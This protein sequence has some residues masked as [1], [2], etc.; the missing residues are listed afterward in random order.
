MGYISSATIA[1]VSRADGTTGRTITMN[2]VSNVADGF[3]LRETGVT[4]IALAQTLTHRTTETKSKD[5][6]IL[7]HSQTLWQWPYELTTNPGV[8]AG[9]VSLSRTGLHVPSNCPA[10]VRADIRT[11]MVNMASSSVGTVGLALVYDPIINGVV[12]F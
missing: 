6:S 3:V 8:V 4:N 7:R 12:P 10:N 5:G 11:Q 9:T 1:G 2:R